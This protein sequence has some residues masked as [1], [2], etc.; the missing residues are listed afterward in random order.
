MAKRKLLDSN[1]SSLVIRE[2]VIVIDL[3]SFFEFCINFLS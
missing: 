3:N 2:P 1:E